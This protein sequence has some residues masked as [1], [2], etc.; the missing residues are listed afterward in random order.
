MKYS[1]IKNQI[2]FNDNDKCKNCNKKQICR[3]CPGKFLMETGS[4]HTP[5]QFY[6][7]L[8]DEIIKEYKND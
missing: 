5:P 8:T 6:C 3:Y 7:D 2:F 1:D 4:Y